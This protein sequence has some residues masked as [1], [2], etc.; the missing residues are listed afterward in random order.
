[1]ASRCDALRKVRR[2]S[3]RKAT[4]RPLGNQPAQ[5][6]GQGVHRFLAGGQAALDG[7]LEEVGVSLGEVR[8][9]GDRHVA[10]RA[11]IKLSRR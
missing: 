5:F 8:P 7:R 6:L 3:T 2:T 11:F 10:R 9:F 1:V 4:R